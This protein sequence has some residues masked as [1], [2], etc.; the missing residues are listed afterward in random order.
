VSL[1]TVVE[2]A[3]KNSVTVHLAQADV[4]RATR[5]WRKAATPSS[6]RSRSVRV[7]RI[8]GGWFT[9]S[10]PTS[11]TAPSSRWSSACANQYI[12]A[13]RAGVQ[14]AQL[15]LKMHANRRPRS[16]TAYI[17]LDTVN[18]ELEAAR[19]QEQAAARL[20]EIEQQRAEA[21]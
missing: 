13:A 9:G 10:L 5:N 12:H 20:V 17:E 11:G 16:S 1:T 4:Q 8:S 14:A 3:Q 2:L 15:A 21:A 19:T 7:F 6:R 18:R